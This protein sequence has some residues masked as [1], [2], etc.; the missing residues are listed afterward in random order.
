MGSC[1]VEGQAAWR[2]GMGEVG[3][4]GLPLGQGDSQQ[5]AP[6]AMQG[7]EPKRTCPPVQSGSTH[8]VSCGRKGGREKSFIARLHSFCPARSWHSPP[9]TGMT[10]QERHPWHGRMQCSTRG[11]P[12][13]PRFTVAPQSSRAASPPSAPRCA[14]AM[15]ADRPSL[16]QQLGLKGGCTGHGPSECDWRLHAVA[17]ADSPPDARIDKPINQPKTSSPTSHT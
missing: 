2:P 5:H 3:Q 7:P 10:S 16:P 14:A 4:H 1:G 6:V 13:P 8:L 15:S 12:N 11:Q 17:G 9:N